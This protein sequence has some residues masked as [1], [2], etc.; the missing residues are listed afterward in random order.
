MSL[1]FE[2]GTVKVLGQ[3]P[4]NDINVIPTLTNVKRLVTTNGSGIALHEDGT[5]TVWG[6]NQSK[7]LDFDQRIQGK[8]VSLGKSVIGSDNFQHIVALLDDGTVYSW[9]SPTYGAIDTPN[10]LEK[11]SNVDKVYS[12]FYQNFAVDE[13]G[14]LIDSWGLR[15]HLF[16]NR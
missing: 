3:G 5:L 16:W 10:K 2:D 8:V 11:P 14:K 4:I 12:G 1:L 6:D 7:E 15:G 13:N 9:G